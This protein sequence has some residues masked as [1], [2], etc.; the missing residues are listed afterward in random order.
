MPASMNVFSLNIS[1]PPFPLVR[2]TQTPLVKM[3]RQHQV[4]VY[5]F[6]RSG[7]SLCASAGLIRIFELDPYMEGLDRNVTRGSARSIPTNERSS[8]T[9][10]NS[11]RKQTAEIRSAA[12]RSLQ[13]SGSAGNGESVPPL[14]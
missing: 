13:C 12:A 9:E 3:M 2:C 11:K 4:K 14:R 7:K 1:V 10:M 5:D 6:L 8:M